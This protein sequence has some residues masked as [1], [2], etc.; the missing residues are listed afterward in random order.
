[1][2]REDMMQRENMSDDLFAARAGDLDESDGAKHDCHLHEAGICA[3][4]SCIN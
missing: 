3:N 4:A 2:Y 1:M